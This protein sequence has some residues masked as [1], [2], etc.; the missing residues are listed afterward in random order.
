MAAGFALMLLDVV[1]AVRRPPV[2]LRAARIGVRQLLASKLFAVL[3]AAGF[4]I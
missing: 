2:G 1:D 3:A 4:S